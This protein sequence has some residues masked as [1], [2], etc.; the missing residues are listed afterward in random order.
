MEYDFIVPS[1]ADPSRI[2]VRYEGANSVSVNEAGE[3]VVETD[4]GEVVEQRPVVYQMSGGDRVSLAGHYLL[5]SEKV[6]GFELPDGYDPNLPLVVDPTLVYST[7]LGGSY[8]DWGQDIAV[9]ASGAAYVSGWTGSTDFP[10]VD[11][12]QEA[13]QGSFDAFVTKLGP[14]CCNHDG[15][16]GDVNYDFQGPDIADLNAL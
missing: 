11:P 10:T 1:G 6:F 7:Y 5:K 9:D 15:I 2:E 16:T 14:P 3:M 12:Y 8:Y 4:W 13:S